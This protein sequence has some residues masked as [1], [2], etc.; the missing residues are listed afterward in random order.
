M[1]KAIK[2]PTK[3][4]LL[5]SLASVFPF[6]GISAQDAAGMEPSEPVDPA[7]F[8][9]MGYAMGL[10]LRL[11]ASSFSPEEVDLILQGMR[12]V[13]QNEDRPANLS[14]LLPEA[15]AVYQKRMSQMQEQMQKKNERLSEQNKAEAEAYFAELSE[16]EGVRKTESGLFYEVLE[17]G[18][19]TSPSEDDAV[20]VNY[21][22]TLIDGTEFDANDG[23]RFRVGGVVPGFS[24]ALQLMQVGDKF[25][26]HLPSELAYGDRAPGRGSP[27]EPGDALIFE[28]ELLSVQSM[29][30]PPSGP[31]PQLPDDLPQPPPPPSGPPP[32]PP[33]GPPPAPPS[34]N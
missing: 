34:P 9:A 12:S 28:V 1:I 18:S 29:P 30:K 24:E 15:Q 6:A 20:V 26:I 14:Q 31:P 22:G 8:R 5:V 25:R 19:G 33:S 11:N 23:A 10:Q 17:E 2:M 16:K 21:K 7:I 27:I 13:A 3:S 32:S 4:L